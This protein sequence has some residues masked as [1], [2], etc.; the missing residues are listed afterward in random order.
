MWGGRGVP[1]RSDL[2]TDQPWGRGF[3]LEVRVRVRVRVRTLGGPLQGRATAVDAATATTMATAT[4]SATAT[5]M[6]SAM[7]IATDTA[8]VAVTA[9][10]SHPA[11]KLGQPNEYLGVRSQ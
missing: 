5:A 1:C 4:A 6:A 3:R 8:T 11:M 7:A 9:R 2:R 10:V